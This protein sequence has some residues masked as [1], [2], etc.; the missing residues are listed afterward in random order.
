MAPF[1][2]S[3]LRR[4]LLILS[5]SGVLPALGVIVYTQ[6][7]ERSQLRQRALDD[8]IR[9]T[10]LA[11]RQPASVIRG[12]QNLLQ[13]LA[14]FPA[15]SSDVGACR[16]VL[17]NVLRDHAGYTNLFVLDPHGASVCSSRAVEQPLVLQD[18]PWFQQAIKTRAIVV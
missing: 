10:T 9:L 2:A 5:L 6:S 17:Q 8:N 13:T 14:Q 18:R 1:L 4:R 15:L 3:P 12:A 7:V 11:A 16:S